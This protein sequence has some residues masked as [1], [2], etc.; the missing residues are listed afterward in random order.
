F[1]WVTKRLMG[2]VNIPLITTNRINTPELAEK[3]LADGC[4]NMVSMARPF[5]A[6][7][8]FVR[9]AEQQ[10]GDEI[11]TCIACNQACLD[12]I[13]KGK[14]AS[15]LVNPRACRE[16]SLNIQKV[17]LSKKVAVVGAGPAGLSAATNAAKAGHEVTLYDSAQEIGGQFNMAKRIPGKYDFYE[18][19]RYFKKQIELHGVNLVLGKRVD[20]QELASFDHVIVATGVVPRKPQIPGIDHAK[21]HSYVEVLSGNAEIGKRVAIVG[22]GGIGFDV[23]EYLMH[24]E[25]E[26]LK[27]DPF[28]EEWGVDKAFDNRGGVKKPNDSKSKRDLVIMQR[29]PGKLGAGLGKTTGWIHRASLKKG[30][31]KMLAEVQYKSISD[32]GFAIEVKGEPHLLEVDNII[33]CAGQH[34]LDELTAG[35]QSVNVSY[36]KIGGARLAGELDA[37]R[38][39]EEGLIAATKI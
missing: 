15:C 26:E 19:I 21:V 10:R 38:A 4:S 27:V 33:I 2:K 37:K 13:F 36:Q 6:D 7:P 1:A 5:L 14:V 31:V 8:E 11:N 29:K 25:S 16:T 9:K 35:L 18:T 22:A 28:L 3:V 24:G 20:A 34:S 12:H 32:E 39:I 30:G 17:S 23:A